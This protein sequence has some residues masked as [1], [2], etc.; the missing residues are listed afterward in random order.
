MNFMF[1]DCSSLVSLDLSG[2]DTSNVREMNAMFSNCSS[3]VFLDLSGFTLVPHYDDWSDEYAD[4]ELGGLFDGAGALRAIILPAGF[5]VTEDMCLTNGDENDPGWTVR[6]DETLTVVSGDG[7]Y[8]VIEA[9]SAVTAF[10]WKA[11]AAVDP[12]CDLNGD[13]NINISDVTA[14]LD[15]LAASGEYD[16]ACD[17]NNDGSVNITDVTYL[18][19]YLAAMH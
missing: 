15:C 12:A 8:A 7:E 6:G 14:L 2:F 5:A 19:D 17:L 11:A 4:P 1:S 18:L 10:V 9:P 13:G 16:A 3:L